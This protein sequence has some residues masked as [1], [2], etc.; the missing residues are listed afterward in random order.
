M[1]SAPFIMNFIL[2]VPLRPKSSDDLP[3][4]RP[5]APPAG[6]TTVKTAASAASVP[7]LNIQAGPA[8]VIV[9][10]SRK[11]WGIRT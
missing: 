9:R 7:G 11:V 10:A 1:V 5:T 3:S 4:R 6:S 2:P 8:A